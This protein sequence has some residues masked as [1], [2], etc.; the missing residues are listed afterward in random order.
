[1]HGLTSKEELAIMQAAGA[2]SFDRKEVLLK[3]FY[4]GVEY[5]LTK[6]LPEAELPRLLQPI[7]SQYF[8]S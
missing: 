8:S 7:N 5:A 3:A 2:D 6:R 4:L 1:M